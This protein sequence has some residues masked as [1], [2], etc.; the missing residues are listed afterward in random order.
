MQVNWYKGSMKLSDGERRSAVRVAG[1]RYRLA[2]APVLRADFGNYSCVS[3]NG[4]GKVR[5]ESATVTLTGAPTRPQVTS[6][7]AGRHRYSYD[8]KW[9]SASP[10]PVLQHRIEYWPKLLQRVGNVTRVRAKRKIS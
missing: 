6:A 5:G 1:K 3:E 10:F 4:L 7:A 2:I 8:L 9:R